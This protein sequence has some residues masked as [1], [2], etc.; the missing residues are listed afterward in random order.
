MPGC[1]KGGRECVYPEPTSSAKR[2]GSTKSK[3]PNDGEGEG[4]SHDEDDF[5]DN[6]L[7]DEG[8]PTRSLREPSNA[9]SPQTSPK[10]IRADSDPPALTHG[11]SP[12]PSTDGSGGY[13]GR[14]Y[15]T[16]P[17]RQFAPTARLQTVGARKLA[18]LSP[19]MQFY[20]EY[21]RTNLTK[22]HWEMKLDGKGFLNKTLIEIALRFEPL[23]YAVVGFAA[24]HFT[25]SKRDGQL[26]DFLGYYQKSVSLLRQTIKQKPNLA[27]IM[28]ILQLATIEVRSSASS[29]KYA[30]F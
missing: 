5:D 18:D 24:Y 25:L 12:S 30:P 22:H 13:P 21:A 16:T 10:S 3:S 23:L 9:N 6:F 11:A 19:D 28:T 15:S 27:T 20:L 29:L 14:A 8:S 26:K 4:S 7:D 1:R 17:A 2:R